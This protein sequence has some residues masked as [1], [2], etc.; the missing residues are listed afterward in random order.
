MSD[1][2]KKLRADYMREYYRKQTPEQRAKR[3]AKVAQYRAKNR[4]KLNAKQ[5]EYI[6]ENPQS[7]EARKRHNRKYRENNKEKYAAHYAVAQALIHGTLIRPSS[8]R[9]GNR[10]R[11]EAHHEDYAKQL[12]VDFLCVPCHKEKHRKE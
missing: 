2:K 12:E 6:K 4:E 10:G 7:N 9:C 1:E 3:L 5:R 8:C 11:L